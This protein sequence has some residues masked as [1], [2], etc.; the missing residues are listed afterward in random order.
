MLLLTLCLFVAPMVAQQCWAQT[1]TLRYE[2][3]FRWDKSYLDTMYLGNNHTFEK[4]AEQLDSIGVS[5]VGSVSIVSQSSPEGPYDRN[6]NLSRRRA[7]TMRSYMENHHSEIVDRLTVVPDG[8]SWGQLRRYIMGDTLLGADVKERLMRIIDD[9]SVPLNVRKRRLSKDEAYGY[10]YKKYYPII[11]NSRIQI[12]YNKPLPAILTYNPEIKTCIGVRSGG[13]VPTPSQQS[14]LQQTP[15]QQ[16][17]LQQAYLPLRDTLLIAAKTNLLYDAVTALNVELEVPIGNHWS[18]AVE[19][20]FPWWEKGNKYCL[21]MWE[22][23]AE[24]R[25]WFGNNVHCA[26]KLKG[27]F[28]GL[29]AMSSKF[30]FQND[31]DL[32]YQGEYWSTGLTYGY[33]LKVSRHFNMELSVSLGYLSSSYRHYYPAYDYS[34]LWRD[35]SK[36]GRI[37][38]WGPTKL[39]VSLVYPIKITYKTDRKRY[40]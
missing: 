10:L 30:D 6:K 1:D 11:R 39:K 7:A 4:I 27:H 8:E 35:E 40:E 31:Y 24:A 9:R 28:L 36:T 25:Y 21:Q 15:S 33:S 13:I 38:Y 14:L 23:G 16:I 32:C 12:V 17:P 5:K 18:V 20:V 26:D 29:Y 2:V 19:D 37:S 34:L 3:H 22:M